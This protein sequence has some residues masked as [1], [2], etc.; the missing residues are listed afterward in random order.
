MRDRVIGLHVMLLAVALTSAGAAAAAGGDPYQRVSLSLAQ[1]LVAM[2]PVAEGY[3]VSVAGG[4]A[5]VDLAEKDLMRPGMELQLYRPGAEMVHPV[6]KQVLGTFETDL[7]FLRLTEVREKYSRGAVEAAEGAAVAAGDRVRVSARRLRALLSLAGSAPGVEA[8][9]LA[10][11]LLGRAAESG[12]FTVVDEPVWTPSLAGA[13]LE[14]VSADPAALRALGAKAA[15]DLLLL[16]KVEAGAPPVV[17]VDVRSLRTGA[18]LGVL[19]EPW[20]APG[21][22]ERPVAVARPAQ[23]PVAAAPVPAPSAPAP[24]SR[25]AVVAQP[26]PSAVPPAAPTGEAEGEY[27]IRE[28]PGGGMALAAADILGEGR[29]E[30]V[31]SDGYGVSLYRWDEKQLAWRWDEGRRGGRRVVALD[32]ADLDGDARAEVLVSTVTWG[33][34]A[35]EIRSWRGARLET[36]GVADGLWL[37]AV[38]RP[39]GPA[40]LLGQRAGIDEML[41]GRVEEYRWRSGSVE[42]VDGTSLP[43]GVGIFG[44]ALAPADG[45][46]AFYTLDRGGYLYAYDASG[47]PLWRSARTYGGYPAPL[48]EQDLGGGSTLTGAAFEEAMLVFQGR[49]FAESAAGGVRVSVPRNFSD[50]GI[51][52]PRLRKLGKGE[53]VLLE[54]PQGLVS[55]EERG[56]SRPFDG[57]VA[58]LA[59]ADV[60]GDGVAETLF[61]VNRFAGPLL[62]DR[63][64]L[65]SWRVPGAAGP[66]K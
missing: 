27:V 59:R 4:E 65:V 52:L 16:T 11:A 8:G 17:T 14:A 58:D 42:R 63:A 36:A 55:L 46:A 32:A 6:T 39:G 61:L 40:L 53:V 29:L 45:P 28:L 51:S 23:P 35:T 34:V 43:R 41:S 64:K 50:A 62:G 20:P 13:P 21:D 30:V 7:G 3:V 19:R 25:P 18:P 1:G 60:D 31:I 56:R 2:F 66:Q 9:P 15:A 12:R 57:Y 47:E 33:R 49:L 5:Y 54:A 38:P 26:A 48:T 10:L 37:R 22:A 44:L 24:D